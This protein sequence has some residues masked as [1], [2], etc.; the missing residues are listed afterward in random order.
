MADVTE[1]P[2]PAGRPLHNADQVVASRN[3]E[4]LIKHTILKSDHFPG[5]RPGGWMLLQRQSCSRAFAPL[6]LAL[7]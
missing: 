1:Q 6:V 5:E 3:G 2:E 4:V 7:A